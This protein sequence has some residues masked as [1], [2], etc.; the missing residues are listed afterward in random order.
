MSGFL[1][2][3]LAT[4]AQS[5]RG[6]GLAFL[7]FRRLQRKLHTSRERPLPSIIQ[8]EPFNLPLPEHTLLRT[9]AYS[10]SAMCQHTKNYNQ[11]FL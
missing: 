7:P 3:L 10:S 5:F 8:D 1:G 9:G 2:P 4:D 6:A 11:S